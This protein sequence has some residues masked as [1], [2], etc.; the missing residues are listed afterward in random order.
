M[1]GKNGA[2]ADAGGPWVVRKKRRA[3]RRRRPVV[4]DAFDLRLGPRAEPLASSVSSREDE[5]ED[6]LSDFETVVACL[7]DSDGDGSHFDDDTDIDF[8]GECRR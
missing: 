2:L 6:R 8:A 5:A 7:P 1:C 4:V 3:G